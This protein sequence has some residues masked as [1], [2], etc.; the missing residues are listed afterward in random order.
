MQLLSWFLLSHFA[1]LSA[2]NVD[3]ASLVM[4]NM[5]IIPIDPRKAQF[6]Q[7]LPYDL[8]WAV[9]DARNVQ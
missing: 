3:L 2:N 8:R 4:S 5:A 1:H 7:M 6:Q 9:S